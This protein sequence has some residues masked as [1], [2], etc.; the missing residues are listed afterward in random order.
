MLFVFVRD[1]NRTLSGDGAETDLDAGLFECF[2]LRQCL[3]LQV[4]GME[5][6]RTGGLAVFS[7]GDDEGGYFVSDGFLGCLGC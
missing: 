4:I 7:F 3:Q 1:G 2:W 5:V 6:R